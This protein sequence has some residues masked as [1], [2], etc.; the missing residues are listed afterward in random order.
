MLLS[1]EEFKTKLAEALH[2]RLTL[3]HP[4]LQEIAKPKKNLPLV[5]K[6]GFAG[7]PS[8]S[9][10]YRLSRNDLLPLSHS[11]IQDSPGR[12]HL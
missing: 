9:G 5:S 3:D 1:K 12:Q 10:I 8:D 11:E 6:N 4:V 7:L 2:S